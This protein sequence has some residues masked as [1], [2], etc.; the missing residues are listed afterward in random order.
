MGTWKAVSFSKEQQEEFGVDEDGKVKDQ[1]KFDKA[2]AAAKEAKKNAEP[3]IVEAVGD[4]TEMK[5]T[6]KKGIGFYANSAC[7]FLKG[8]DAKP[9]DG[10]KP[11]VDAKPAVDN[12]RISGLGEAV[13]V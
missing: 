13:N 3:K 1:E 6:M 7:S 9:A 10:D 2:V 8:I 11:A 12:L 4:A 5:V